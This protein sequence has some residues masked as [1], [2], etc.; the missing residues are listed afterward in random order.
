MSYCRHKAFLSAQAGQFSTSCGVRSTAS[1]VTST[2]TAGNENENKDALV[3]E[4][5]KGNISK[6]MHLYL[7]RAKEHQRFM[8][9][10]EQEFV[11][12]RRH[13][14]NMMG[15]DPE[16]F[17]QKDIDEAIRYLFPSGLFEPKARPK[18]KPPQEIYPKQKAAQFDINGRPHHPFFYT[19]KPNYY[20]IVH[21]TVGKL[22]ALNSQDLATQTKLIDESVEFAAT[23]WISKEELEKRILEYISDDLYNELINCLE[24]LATHPRGGRE[25]EYLKTFRRTL[26]VQKLKS[27][28]PEVTLE[29]DGT[30]S[31]TV[32]K[33]QK[34]KALGSVT[35]TMPG[36]GKFCING[37][38]LEYF[39]TIKPRQM[40]L[41]PLQLVDW[42]GTVDIKCTMSSTCDFSDPMSKARDTGNRKIAEAYAIRWGISMGLAALG[43][44]SEKLRLA[45]L[46]T[47][48]RRFKER[49]HIAHVGARAAWTW[50]KR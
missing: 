19:A 1:P 46:L 3:Q 16:A 4:G 25:V 24:R 20:F 40:L 21:E 28:L 42:L 31:V 13:L 30:Q 5:V 38:G 45:G 47:P 12:G 34:K 14:A 33:C 9:D 48:D 49:N 18:M 7:E 39:D 26:V 23:A 43:A 27:S 29:P 22:N 35:V 2:A 15:K 17:T 41:S 11:F 37:K 6:A 44:D 32:N 10:Q 36:T 8:K 50:K